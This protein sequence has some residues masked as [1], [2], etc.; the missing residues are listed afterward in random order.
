MRLCILHGLRKLFGNFCIEELLKKGE[1]NK[2]PEETTGPVYLK[3]CYLK[4]ANKDNITV[5]DSKYLYPIDWTVENYKKNGN[6]V[7]LK[8]L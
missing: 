8:I 4:F 3:K 7:I 6:T 2:R 5:L 1:D